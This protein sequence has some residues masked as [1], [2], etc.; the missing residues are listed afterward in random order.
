MNLCIN[1]RH[2]KPDAGSEAIYDGCGH[3][4]VIELDPVRGQHKAPYAY[5][6]RMMGRQCGPNAALI[7]YD[8]GEP[9]TVF[10]D[11]EDFHVV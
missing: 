1:C 4:D 7:E 3:P 2:H 11:E 8:P 9:S 6:T 10:P 5:I